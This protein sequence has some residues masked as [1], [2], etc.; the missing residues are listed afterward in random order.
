MTSSNIVFLVVFSLFAFVLTPIV[1]YGQDINI[2]ISPSVLIV[3]NDNSKVLTVHTDISIGYVSLSEPIELCLSEGDC[4]LMEWYEVDDCG[5]F[6][7]KFLIDHIKE[8]DLTCE[9]INTFTLEGYT[10]DNEPFIGEDKIYVKCTEPQKNQ[11]WTNG[12]NKPEDDE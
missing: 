9:E 10:T 2:V 11:K 1:S 4:A 3:E 7:A 6:V 8:L 12:E 5:N